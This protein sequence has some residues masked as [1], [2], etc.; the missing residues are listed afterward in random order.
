MPQTLNAKPEDFDS[1]EK[2]SKFTVN[3]V[4]CGQRGI[5]LANAFAEAGFKVVCCDLDQCVLRKVTRGKTCFS[6]Q[7]MEN[8]LKANI[9]AGLIDAS[10]EVKKVVAQSDIVAIAVGAKLDE[11]KKVDTSEVVIACRQVGTALQRGSLVFYC[12][13]SGFGFTEGTVKETLE[14]TSGLKVGADFGFS[15]MPIHLS[16]MSLETMNLTLAAPDSS[17]LNTASAVMKAL[18][19]DIKQASDIKTAE[20][21]ALFMVSKRDTDTALAN[22]LAIFCENS[23]TDFSETLKLIGANDSS[24]MPTVSGEESKSEAYLLLENAENMNAKLRLPALARQINEDMVKHA[25]NLTQESLRTSGKTLRRA[26]VTVLGTADPSGTMGALVKLLEAKGAKMSLYDPA[27]K[28]ATDSRIIKSSISEAAEGADCI[29][30]L[31]GQEQFK[32]LNLKKLKPL[33]KA[34]AVMVDLTGM[35]EPQKVR[36]EGFIYCGFGKGTE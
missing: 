21:A 34:P 28:D 25:V 5:L 11:Q 14:N 18:K 22:E 17:S 30:V 16:D 8:K 20:L 9:K 27:R 13:I 2:C 3:V 7:E 33:M 24:F 35:L 12:G 26:R 32:R 19:S 29:V 15:Y 4:G 31:S 6:Q 23:K 36:G 1:K 10:G